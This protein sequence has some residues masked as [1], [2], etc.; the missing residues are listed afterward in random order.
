MM[1]AEETAEATTEELCRVCLKPVTTPFK[2]SE[3]Y[4][5]FHKT[6]ITHEKGRLRK[7][8][9]FVCSVCGHSS[10]SFEMRVG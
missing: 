4:S 7:K 10:S 5:V 8:K 6:C 9:I 1:N 3:C 2:C